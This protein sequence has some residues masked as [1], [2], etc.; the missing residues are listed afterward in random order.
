M[1][2]KRVQLTVSLLITAFFLY[3]AFKNVPLKSLWTAIKSVNYMWAIPFMLITVLSMYFRTIRWKYLLKPVVDV[4]THKLFSP[5][6]IC[7]FLNSILP[8]RAGEFARAYLVGR[9]HKTPFSSAFATVV[10]ERMADALGLLVFFVVMLALVPLGEGFSETWGSVKEIT[11]G[12]II[13][14]A[15][16]GLGCGAA[17]LAGLAYLIFR[18]A[19]RRAAGQEKKHGFMKL[20]GKIENPWRAITILTVLA[21]L[22]VVG[23]VLFAAGTFVDASRVYSYGKEY[24]IDGKMLRTLSTKL[25]IVGIVLLAG[26]LLMLWSPF[27]RFVQTCVRWTPLL[28]RKFKEGLNSFIE[29]FV[30]G[31]HSLREPKIL[32]WVIFHT[33]TVWLTIGWS[34]VLMANGFPGMEMTFLQGMAV[35]IIICIAILIPAAPGYWGLYEVGC[36]LSLKMLGIVTPDSEGQATALGFSLVLHFLQMVPILALGAFFILR[37]RVGIAE[38]RSA[39]GEPA[40]ETDAA[41]MAEPPAAGSD[42]AEETEKPEQAER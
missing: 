25:L 37:R 28:P 21:T 33:A 16:L 2:Q 4:P 26:A 29:T 13:L 11:G 40:D 8:G 9:D 42:T 5:L 39:G 22:C 12:R 1:K 15:S 19:M 36:I 41:K 14:L 20:L 34:I 24:V 27:Q 10:V 18:A 32:F 38:L 30:H 3:L 17:L 35:C 7:F 23:I 31:F 6:I